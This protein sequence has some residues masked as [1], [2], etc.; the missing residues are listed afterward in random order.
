[1]APTLSAVTQ[2]ALYLPEG[3]W[4]DYWSDR[5]L[6]GRQAI[7]ADAPLD[8][9]LLYV[10]HGT[11]L[12]KIPEDVMT[13]VAEK[14]FEDRKVKTLDDRRVHELCPGKEPRT[15][16]DFEPRHLDYDPARGAL[17]IRG[18]PANIRIS[19]KFVYPSN[20]TPNG[21]A[22]PGLRRRRMA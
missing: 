5:C 12:P 8:R 22:L 20:A 18:G 3:T 19:W 17:R 13:L 16:T 14:D 6:T 21:R 15:V 9:I 1:M 10:R 2:R 4:I 7:S 11:I